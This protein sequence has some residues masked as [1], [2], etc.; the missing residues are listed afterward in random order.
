MGMKIT[1][2]TGSDGF[3]RQ[4]T[5]RRGWEQSEGVE[6]RSPQCIDIGGSRMSALQDRLEIVIP[7]NSGTKKKKDEVKDFR[8][9]STMR[10]RI[11]ARS[12]GSEVTTM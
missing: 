11:C 1:V 7:M 9:T 6:S 10:F 12:L 2:S 5:A 3:S 4:T 8:F